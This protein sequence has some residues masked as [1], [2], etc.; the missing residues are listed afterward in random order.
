IRR[1]PS[2]STPEEETAVDMRRSYL[3]Q[4]LVWFVAAVVFLAI[5][6]S[7]EPLWL[8]NGLIL[9]I[10]SLSRA[11]QWTLAERLEPVPVGKVFK[12]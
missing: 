2:P 1:L 4:A 5:G 11:A 12:R 9:F 8:V 10:L 3:T 6:S 7:A